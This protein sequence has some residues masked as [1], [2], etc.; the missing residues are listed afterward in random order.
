MVKKS[1]SKKKEIITD[2]DYFLGPD[3]RKH[4]DYVRLGGKKS[5]R[6]RK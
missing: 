4:K 1:K 3:P 6:G 5:K 2:I